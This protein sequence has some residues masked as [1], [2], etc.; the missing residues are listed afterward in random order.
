MARGRGVLALL[1]VAVL[2]AA[3]A[4]GPVTEADTP[5][6]AVEDSFVAFRQAVL[7]GDGEQAAAL[8]TAASR[9]YY[10]DRADVATSAGTGPLQTLPPPHT[11]GVPNIRTALPN[12]TKH[13]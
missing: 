7:D 10:R 9:H 13:N 3:C 4:T 5:E 8:T 12:T 1:L 6:R 11:P 2:P